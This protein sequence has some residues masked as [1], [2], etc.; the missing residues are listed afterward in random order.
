MG[1]AKTVTYRHPGIE[2]MA[3]DDIEALIEHQDDGEPSDLCG[4]DRSKLYVA[5]R[6][7]R[8]GKPEWV[9]AVSPYRPAYFV[10]R[11]D[12]VMFVAG[13]TLSTAV[14]LVKSGVEVVE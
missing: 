3:T 7:I 1:K 10:V 9:V 11:G 12:E 4:L 6:I 2:A 14:S 8:K 5:V 13:I